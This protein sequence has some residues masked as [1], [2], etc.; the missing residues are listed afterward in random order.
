MGLVEDV[1]SMRVTGGSNSRLSSYKEDNQLQSFSIL[2][3][4]IGKARNECR[5]TEE[6]QSFPQKVDS[7]AGLRSTVTGV[8]RISKGGQMKRGK[9]A[10]SLSLTLKFLL[11]S[12]Q[13]HG[14]NTA[15]KKGKL[16]HV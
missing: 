8:A 16:V 12:F 2:D 6:R 4:Q 15:Y 9:R 3:R 1:I 5:Q 13:N 11:L 10:A 7:A 14:V